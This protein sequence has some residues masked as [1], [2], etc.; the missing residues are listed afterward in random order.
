[1]FSVFD[2][3]FCSSWTTRWTAD[4]TL[5][6]NFP[7]RNSDFRDMAPP[8]MASV[9]A[10]HQ[11]LIQEGKWTFGLFDC[12]CPKVKMVKAATHLPCWDSFKINPCKWRGIVFGRTL[13]ECYWDGLRQTR[14]ARTVYAANLG[15]E[16]ILPVRGVGSH[17]FKSEIKALCWMYF[18]MGCIFSCGIGQVFSLCGNVCFNFSACYSC[19]AREKIRRRYK[20]PPVFGLPP[21]IDDFIAHFFCLYCSVY[22]EM[23]ELTIRGVDGPGLNILDVLPRSYEAAPGGL[24][25]IAARKALVDKMLSKPPKMF[26]SRPEN[27][28]MDASGKVKVE[29]LG[30]EESEVPNVTLQD[31]KSSTVI[32]ISRIK[33]SL[34][35]RERSDELDTGSVASSNSALGWTS[36]CTVIPRV[37]EMSREMPRIQSLPLP[38]LQSIIGDE[39]AGIELNEDERRDTL[40]R[41]WSVAY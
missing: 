5:K 17:G 38:V 14:W 9:Y 24:E 25:A 8:D 33:V 26:V 10:A 1:M 15:R 6:E 22:Q 7:P 4:E 37:Q 13:E 19:H 20:L 34:L 40:E 31:L 2:R 30:Q 29:G 27:A 16:Y 23:R 11:S 39:T 41:S 36:H 12:W 32:T 18:L 21:G 3:I 35:G 28:E